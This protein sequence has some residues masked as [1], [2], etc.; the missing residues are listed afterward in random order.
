[1]PTVQLRS[2]RGRA[3]LILDVTPSNVKNVVVRTAPEVEESNSICRVDTNDPRQ[4]FL[5]I[6]HA[7][8]RPGLVGHNALFERKHRLEDAKRTHVSRSRYEKLRRYI[9]FQLWHQLGAIERA[10]RDGVEKTASSI[11]CC[12]VHNDWLGLGVWQPRP[13]LRRRVLR[14]G[15]ASRTK[16]RRGYGND[17]RKGRDEKAT[18]HVITLLRR[19]RRC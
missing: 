7:K 10:V 9:R 5:R 6:A 15:S 13:G 11:G 18:H 4:D 14:L 1:M 19:I 8:E 12:L 17:G 2:R 3:P 16:H